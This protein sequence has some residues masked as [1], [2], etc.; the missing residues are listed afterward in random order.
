MRRDLDRRLSR[1]EAKLDAQDKPAW[2]HTKGLA[3]LLQWDR[4]HG[5]DDNA[6][7]LGDSDDPGTLTG[8]SSLLSYVKAR[9]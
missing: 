1:I 5:T 3:I 8:L 4:E 7:L 2:V 6:D 9:V